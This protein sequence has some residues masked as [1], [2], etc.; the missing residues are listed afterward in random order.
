MRKQ[1]VGYFRGKRSFFTIE[2]QKRRLLIY[3]SLDPETVQPWSD[4]AMRDTSEIG[5]YGM[6]DLEYSVRAVEQLNELRALAKTA[7][8]RSAE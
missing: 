4:E 6:G 2:I 5:H 3:L 8:D 1:Y 7:Y